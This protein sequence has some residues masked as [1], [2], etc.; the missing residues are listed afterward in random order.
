MTDFLF[1]KPVHH[2]VVLVVL[3]LTFTAWYL[4]ALTRNIKRD[5]SIYELYSPAQA[6]GLALYFNLI[7]IGFFR[8]REFAR[9]EAEG[10]L[11]GLNIF[12]FALLGLAVLRNRERVRRLV[13]QAGESAGNWLTAT[14]PAPYILA[15]TLLVGA[16]VILILQTRAGMR[17]EWSLS[18]AVFR[19]IFLVFWLTRDV[20]YLQWMN[21]R[22]GRR[23]LVMG[24]VYLWVFYTCVNV[25]FGMLDLYDTPR[26]Q[27]FAAIFVPAPSFA[28]EL[29]SWTDDRAMWL[30]ALAA[31]IAVSALFVD[32]QRRKLAELSGSSAPAAAPSAQ[33]ASP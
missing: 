5:P 18:L 10:L 22:Q 30:L 29:K 20:L 23:Q 2:V 13:R 32:L 27:A 1:G 7:I 28:L 3:Y 17:G 4:L 11:A 15:G 33:P 16:A 12:L 14:W 8:W 24:V 21:L 25:L 6:L 31:Q 19:W 26:G 9:L